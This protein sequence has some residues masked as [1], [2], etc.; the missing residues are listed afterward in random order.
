MIL[1]VR[2]MML[3]DVQWEDVELLQPQEITAVSFRGGDDYCHPNS[4]EKNKT[5]Q[6]LNIYHNG[7]K[8]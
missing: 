5:K 8:N 2:G 1:K 6:F 7:S 4:G 3:Q